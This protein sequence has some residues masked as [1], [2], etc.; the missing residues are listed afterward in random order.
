MDGVTNAVR[1]KQSKK[2][3]AFESSGKKPY[4]DVYE[5]GSYEPFWEC[6]LD[7]A[8]ELKKIVNPQKDVPV[9]RDIYNGIRTR[10]WID[11][12]KSES[13]QWSYIIYKLEQLKYAAYAMDLMI[14]KNASTG[15]FFEGGFPKQDTRTNSIAINGNTYTE[16]NILD[17][18]EAIA[19]KHGLEK[20]A[21]IPRFVKVSNIDNELKTLMEGVPEGKHVLFIT[22]YESLGTGMNP[23]YR[24]IVNGVL[25]EDVYDFDAIFCDRITNIVPTTPDADNSFDDRL[26]I[27][28]EYQ[29]DAIKQGLL[30]D[31]KPG[32][33]S[34]RIWSSLPYNLEK[35]LN[36][37]EWA[38]QDLY[39]DD[40]TSPVRTSIAAK[41]L[42]AISRKD[43]GKKLGNAVIV[44]ITSELA[45][46]L[47]S[48]KAL[49]EDVPT[50]IMFDHVIATADHYVQTHLFEV[51]KELSDKDRDLI[52]GYTV[53][54]TKHF[55]QIQ[56]ILHEISKAKSE[57]RPVPENVINHY[58]N[59][60]RAAMGLGYDGDY[61]FY[62][63]AKTADKWRSCL[64]LQDKSVPAESQDMSQMQNA[65]LTNAPKN[66]A[67][68][69]Q[70][71]ETL[72]DDLRF[73]VKRELISENSFDRFRVFMEHKEDIRK[74]GP[75]YPFFAETYWI[76]HGAFYEE[77]AQALSEKGGYLY[78]GYDLTADVPARNFEDFDLRYAGTNV[79]VDVKGFSASRSTGL[80][81]TFDE[82][83]SRLPEKCAVVFLNT[84][85]QG[86][87]PSIM[88][89][90][91]MMGREILWIHGLGTYTEREE[92]TRDRMDL[93]KA[94]LTK[95]CD[96]YSLH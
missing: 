81:K 54:N 80:K 7:L 96:K 68:M 9:I 17:I 79:F 40:K 25:E 55:S 53:E 6:A 85:T 88:E 48:W 63:K 16:N 61:G 27:S 33:N 15:L 29:Y 1:A 76:C 60:R 35:I 56:N 19:E 12:K 8:C 24:K 66:K 94:A 44:S 14:E 70:I 22:A 28:A 75:L 23:S 74:N 21:I 91:M 89:S 37:Q 87:K 43:R 38:E 32:Y 83:L 4:F 65:Y 10:S 90:D 3:K 34:S 11:K 62:T 36:G 71:G 72:I 18:A 20:D 39:K 47:P 82:K 2:L 45:E 78:N 64:G 59:I 26:K 31:N 49:Y 95:L 77:I 67:T 73:Y 51:Q 5:K 57:G 50:G 93:V 13:T 41:I 92:D 58:N 30:E 86:R 52:E 69:N 84:R 42:Q 46:Q